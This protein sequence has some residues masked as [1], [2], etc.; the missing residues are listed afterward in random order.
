MLSPKQILAEE[1]SGGN[2]AELAS[3]TNL[4]RGPQEDAEVVGK[5]PKGTIL[6]LLGENEGSWVKIE[7]E[8]VGGVEQGWIDE[9]AIKLET[10]DGQTD[11]KTKKENAKKKKPGR[12]RRIPEDEMAVLKRD[13]SFSYGIYGGGNYGVMAS[14]YQVELLQGLGLQGGG[15][16]GFFLNRDMSLGVEVGMTQL[17]G[18]ASAETAANI[19]RSGTARLIDLAAVYEYLYQEFRFFGAL[20]YSLG[21]GIADFRINEPPS[22][23]DFSGLW[24]KAGAGYSFQLGQVANLVFKGFYGYS[25]NRT[26]V[27]FQ[28][29]GVSAYL[30]FRG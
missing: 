16:V 24:L 22:A 29:F 18:T 6:N 17:S 13:S 8:L 7:V 5:L 11:G 2:A 10:E 9:A 25:F 4:L 26:F 12:K 30:E 1:F 23:S 15:F 19:S 27:G 20:Q 14:S 28:N 3:D 21:V